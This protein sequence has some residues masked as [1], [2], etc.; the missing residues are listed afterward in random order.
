M[1][2]MY[3]FFVGMIM[4]LCKEYTYRYNKT[5]A[6]QIMLEWLDANPVRFFQPVLLQDALAKAP[7]RFANRGLPSKLLPFP[8]SIGSS[9]DASKSFRPLPRWA[10]QDNPV[11][12][13]RLY[14]WIEKANILKWTKRDCP[15]WI[16]AIDTLLRN[17]RENSAM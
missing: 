14:Y 8:L 7:H 2:M 16:T 15:P 9:D 5:H 4:Q 11:K 17:K 3:S 1:I 12:T 13:Y 10:K 6:C